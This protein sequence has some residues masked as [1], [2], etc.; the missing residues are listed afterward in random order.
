M[1]QKYALKGF[2][3]HQARSAKI[4][5]EWLCQRLVVFSCREFSFGK[6]KFELQIQWCSK[7]NSIF[8]LAGG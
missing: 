1:H 5:V 3:W 2:V 4:M 7:R 6:R 8:R